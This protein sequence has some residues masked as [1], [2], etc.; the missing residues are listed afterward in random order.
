MV[1]DENKKEASSSISL[2]YHNTR[3]SPDESRKS[4][5]LGLGLDAIRIQRTVCAL[6]HVPPR[7]VNDV[8][9]FFPDSE[10]ALRVC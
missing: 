2:G 8:I 5:V 1:V 4:L 6:S 3:G 7:D 10:R 9:T